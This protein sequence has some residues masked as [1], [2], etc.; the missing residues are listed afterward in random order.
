MSEII[1]VGDSITDIY[2]HVSE[3]TNPENDSPAY[4]IKKRKET[5][6]GASNVVKCLEGL[7]NEVI[8]LTMG[9]TTKERIFLDDK[10]ICRLDDDKILSMSSI[11]YAETLKLI[12]NSSAEYVVVSDYNKGYLTKNFC[13]ELEQLGK[14][15]ILD[16]KPNHLKWFKTP[17]LI[18]P[19]L[20]ELREMTKINN[21]KIA[22]MKLAKKKKCY[23]LVTLGSKG[24]CL[25]SKTGMLTYFSPEKTKCIDVTGA[26]D[27][28]ISV[29]THFLTN[30]KDIIWATKA[31]NIAG[32]ISVSKNGCYC[33]PIKEI[34]KGE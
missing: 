25:F 32:A 2:S 26:G 20:K 33:P 19:N 12:K 4:L 34:N 13:Y 7:G 31:A 14:K 8:D 24:M 5:R 21:Y 30:N 15:L 3:K 28:V 9:L 27:T 1:V 17:F 16:I 29:L 18:K 10:Y 6:G 23:V 11:F 22:G